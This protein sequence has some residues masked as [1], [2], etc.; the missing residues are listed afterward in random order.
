[1]LTAQRHKEGSNICEIRTGRFEN[2]QIGNLG[3]KK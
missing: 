3:H 2:E 1:M